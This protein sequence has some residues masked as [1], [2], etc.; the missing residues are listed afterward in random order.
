MSYNEGKS[1]RRSR[2]VRQLAAVVKGPR[3]P[4]RL[5]DLAGARQHSQ[6]IYRHSNIYTSFFAMNSSRYEKWKLPE[7]KAELRKREARVSGKNPVLIERFVQS[8]RHGTCMCLI[9]LSLREALIRKGSYI[10]A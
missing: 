2:F 1:E 6:H 10:I 4:N 3:N 7:L 8:Y 9:Y 5:Q